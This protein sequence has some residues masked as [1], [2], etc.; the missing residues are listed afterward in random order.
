MTEIHQYYDLPLVS[1]SYMDDVVNLQIPICI[2]AYQQQT[3]ELISSR[4]V[5]VP[6]HPNRKSLDEKHTFTWLKPEHDV[7]AVS[8][9]AWI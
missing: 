2:K 6:Y 8:S 9:S 4:T 3:L 5:P 1:Y 7:L